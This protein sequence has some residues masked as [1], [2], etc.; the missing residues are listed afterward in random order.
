MTL[1]TN[2][3]K[4]YARRN[5]RVMQRLRLLL[6]SCAGIVPLGF[7]F[8]F[9]Q[10]EAFITYTVTKTDCLALTCSAL[11]IG[12]ANSI[13]SVY[14]ERKIVK[15]EYQMKALNLSSYILAKTILEA[16]ICALEA[17]LFTATVYFVCKNGIRDTAI[18]VPLL[19]V[20]GF[21]IF[22][23]ADMF[24]LLLSSAAKND[25]MAI[26]SMILSLLFL[27]FISGF[28]SHLRSSFAIFLSNLTISKWG[29]T[30]MFSIANRVSL[31]AE[32]GTSDWTMLHVDEGA[33]A[34]S[35]LTIG[36]CWLVMIL[37][38]LFCIAA[39]MRILKLVRY[40]RR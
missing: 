36:K 3:M 2:Q 16:T 20:T 35:Y 22:F 23:A 24:A 30:A 9:G 6:I 40:D 18:Q 29:A 33:Y 14:P 7:I 10:K 4:V 38:S 11:F 13:A 5:I 27:L 34:F 39:S 1:N 28:V 25:L 12:M 32:K 31:V 8:L 19:Y 15:F 21:L 26:G 17:I 37:I